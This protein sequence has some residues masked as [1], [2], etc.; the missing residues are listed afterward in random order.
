LTN[1]TNLSHNRPVRLSDSWRLQTQN[2]SVARQCVLRSAYN[3]L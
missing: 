2:H 1:V 3:S